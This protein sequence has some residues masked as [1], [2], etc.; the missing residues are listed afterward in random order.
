MFP[1]F[2]SLMILFALLAACAAAQTPPSRSTPVGLPTGEGL[3]VR[4]TSTPTA[5]VI[6]PT[7]TLAPTSTPEPTATPEPTVVQ[8]EVTFKLTD[9]SELT[10]TCFLKNI[11]ESASQELKDQTDKTL[12]ETVLRYFVDKGVDWGSAEYNAESDES[13]EQARKMNLIP[14]KENSVGGWFPVRASGAKYEDFFGLA[15]MRIPYQGKDAS[16]IV[17]RASDKDFPKHRI[18]AQIDPETATSLIQN[19]LINIPTRPE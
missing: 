18:C 13:R 17:A 4:E 1:K 10:L 11:P 2:I 15:I 3:E 5:L 12:L 9:G 19:N 7:E 16:L 8:K 6:V 14:G